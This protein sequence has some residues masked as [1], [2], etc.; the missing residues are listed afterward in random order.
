MDVSKGLDKDGETTIRKTTPA[1]YSGWSFLLN[2]FNQLVAYHL[3]YDLELLVVLAQ[4]VPNSTT[5]IIVAYFLIF[6]TICSPNFIH[7]TMAISH[8]RTIING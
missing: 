5:P 3:Y 4:I 8:H 1:V 6:R 2:N 7:P